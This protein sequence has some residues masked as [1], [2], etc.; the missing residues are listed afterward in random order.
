V[1]RGPGKTQRAV[2]A[3]LAGLGGV[4]MRWIPDPE[5][6]GPWLFVFE[7]AERIGVSESQIHNAVAGLRRRGLVVT[8]PYAAE[9]GAG[10]QR[11]RVL[12]VWSGEHAEFLERRRA[13]HLAEIEAENSPDRG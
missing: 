7:L 3:E 13:A 2:L 6:I 9:Q 12:T 10:G 1:S 5:A 4:D 8:V 11:R